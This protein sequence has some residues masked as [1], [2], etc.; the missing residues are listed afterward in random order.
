M[1]DGRGHSKSLPIPNLYGQVK[2]LSEAGVKWV[3]V[4]E[5]LVSFILATPEHKASEVLADSV[6]TVLRK[7]TEAMLCK[8][9]KDKKSFINLFFFQLWI[10]YWSCL[11]PSKSVHGVLA[12]L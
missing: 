2:V 10:G 1:W 5:W 3:L 7:V 6:A 8:K 4:Q 9:C 11:L 12:Y